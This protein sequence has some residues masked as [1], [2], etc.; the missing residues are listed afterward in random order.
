VSFR[1]TRAIPASGTDCTSQMDD[2]AI[3]VDG[4]AAG[5]SSHL[6]YSN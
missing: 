4:A 3:S 5:R 6:H 2:A 1:P